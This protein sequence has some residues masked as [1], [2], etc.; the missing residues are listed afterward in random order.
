M[1]KSLSW[2]RERL[3]SLTVSAPQGVDAASVLEICGRAHIFLLTP[4][5]LLVARQNLG[6]F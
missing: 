6:F 1:T 5:F 4:F 3:W 2:M